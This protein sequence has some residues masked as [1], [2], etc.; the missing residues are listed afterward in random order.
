MAKRFDMKWLCTI[1]FVLL[2]ASCSSQRHV[3]SSSE[4]LATE[5]TEKSIEQTTSVTVESWQQLDLE[6]ECIIATLT[7][8]SIVRPDGEILYNPRL[9]LNA[10]KP[11]VAQESSALSKEDAETKIDEATAIQTETKSEEETDT[12]SA[13]VAE[14]V[15][16]NWLLIGLLVMG[17]AAVII[18][19]IRKTKTG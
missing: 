18:I 8:D 3:S 7:A 15:K 17:L 4:T 10:E 13:V 5:L 12:E 6:A 16:T 19:V 11:K 1:V 14:P 2:I 9:E